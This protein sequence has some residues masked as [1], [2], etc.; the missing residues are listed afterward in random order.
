MTKTWYAIDG[1]LEPLAYSGPSYFRFPVALAE[2]GIG[3][4]SA[5]GDW[6]NWRMRPAALGLAL[7]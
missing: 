6:T 5:R 2:H 1:T 4:Y 3:T 7:V